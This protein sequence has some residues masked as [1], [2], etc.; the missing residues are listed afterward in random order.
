MPEPVVL[1]GP[2]LHALSDAALVG[3]VSGTTLFAE[4]EPNQKERVISALRKAGH[5][6][7]YLGDGINDAPALHAA[8]VGIAVDSGADVAK[9]AADFV[10]LEHDLAVLVRGVEEGRRT[11]ANTLKYI[12]M[13]T[14]ANFGNMLSMAIASVVIPFLPLLPR[15]VLLVN[16]LTDLPEMTI[17]GDRVDPEAVVRPERFD[18]ALVRRFMLAFGVLSTF[19]DLATFAMLLV[20]AHASPALFRTGWFVESVVSACLIV[21]VLR[22]RRSVARSRPSTALIGATLAVVALVLALP[23]TPFAAPLGLVAL[24]AWLLGLILLVVAAYVVST[25]VAKRAFYR[26]DAP[27]AVVQRDSNARSRFGRVRGA[28]PV[29]R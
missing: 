17:A 4:I 19:F 20:L 24:P 2:E 1:R 10:L 23:Y 13:A 28:G 9:E 27:P 22:T 6:V 14:S 26:S 15:Q 21:L 3:R 29:G 25:S 12:F 18:L 7:G 5:V 8:D 16:L 11:F